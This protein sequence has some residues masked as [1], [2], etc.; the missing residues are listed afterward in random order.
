M[1]Q[2]ASM[3]HVYLQICVY[4]IVCVHA[5]LCSTHCDPMDCSP[6]VSSVHEI[7]QVRILE[8]VAISFS[9]NSSSP[10]SP[11][12]FSCIAGRFFTA[13]PP[14]EAIYC[15]L[16][17][18]H[19]YSQSSWVLLSS[20]ETLSKQIVKQ[21]FLEIHLELVEVWSNTLLG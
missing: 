7:S 18:I 4:Y 13:E 11:A 1:I 3:I 14:G 19:S 10:T 6:P 16:D 9:R 8:W 15:I 21:K 2:C 20:G 12:H 17:I 5:Q